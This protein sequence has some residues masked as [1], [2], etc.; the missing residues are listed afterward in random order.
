MSV[1]P[2][3][4]K[5]SSRKKDLILTPSF[6][7]ATLT[8]KFTKIYINSQKKVIELLKKSNYRQSNMTAEERL[9]L[10][11]LPQNRNLTIK[12]ADKEGKIVI[13]DTAE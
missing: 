7:I 4:T 11:Y 8:F 10:K 1:I 13:M 6:E 2:P 5:C 9:K 12:G 3:L